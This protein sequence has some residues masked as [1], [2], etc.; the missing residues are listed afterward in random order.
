MRRQKNISALFLIFTIGLEITNKCWI[1]PV[2]LT[3]VLLICGGEFGAAAESTANLKGKGKWIV[4]QNVS[5]SLHMLFVRNLTLK[6][7]VAPRSVVC[8][9]LLGRHFI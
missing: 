6:P 4:Y 2:V 8:K 5:L 1:F 7:F 9:Y 3:D